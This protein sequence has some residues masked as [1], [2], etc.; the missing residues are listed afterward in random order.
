MNRLRVLGLS[1]VSLTVGYL[2]F[3]GSPGSSLIPSADYKKVVETDVKLIQEMLSKGSVDEK[4]SKKIRGMGMMLAAYAQGTDAALR[5]SALKLVAA[6]DKG[7][8][9]E[10]KT[11]ASKLTPSAKSDASKA[12][13]LNKVDFDILMRLFSRLGLGLERDLDEMT[14]VKGFSAEQ[15][16]KLVTLGYRMAALGELSTH[17]APEKD[18]GKKTRKAF[19]Q[20][21]GDLRAGS[22]A[23][24]QAAKGKKEGDVTKAL[25]RVSV[26]C[27]K[28]HEIFRDE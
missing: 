10:A 17:F 13:P 23:L 4:T 8:T 26:S 1:V 15:Y 19:L 11:I 14:E 5:A 3:A 16:D 22:L 12:V 7:N 27:R 18:E 24:A 6:M 21:S 2:A 20:F 28:C 9:A 25:E